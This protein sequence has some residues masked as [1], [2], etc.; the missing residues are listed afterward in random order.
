MNN[1]IEYFYN[2]K[3]DNV[4]NYNNYYSFIYNG[5]IYKLYLY[6]ENDIN[7][8]V[9]INKRLIGHTLISE[10]I[11]NKDNEPISIY[12]GIKYILIKIFTHGNRIT[13]G[14]I[15]YFS[16][17]LYT[18]NLNINWGLLWSNKIDYIEELIAENGKKYPIIVDSFNYF[19]GLAEN[20]ISYYNNIPIDNNYKY[21]LGHK[22]I[23]VSDTDEILYNPL[24]IIFDYRVRDVAEYIKN[25]FFL[26][27]KNIFN[28]LNDYFMHNKLSI[29]DVNLLISRILYPSFYFELYEDILINNED[30]KIIVPIVNS[31]PRY[32]KYLSTIIGY[33]K[34]MYDIDD[35]LWLT[36]K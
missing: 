3:A 17:A 26:N 11:F 29:T 1:L 10:I 5:Y 28:E 2:I 12:N 16:N 21:Y 24:N 19:V 31:L 36:K 34:N 22:R 25:S 20:A 8:M 13:L 35:I 18:S 27:N 23:K 32:E 33:F 6:D 30:E 7:L 15:Y 4:K 14:D 9:D